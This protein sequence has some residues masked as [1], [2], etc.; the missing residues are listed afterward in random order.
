MKIDFGLQIRQ[1]HG[2]KKAGKNKAEGVGC[3]ITI[4]QDYA[5][6]FA[7]HFLKHKWGAVFICD[8]GNF[9]FVSSINNVIGKHAS[10][11]Y[12]G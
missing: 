10:S 7:G 4:N 6:T 1:T 5:S 2:A 8:G 11:L 12:F 3:Y 9:G